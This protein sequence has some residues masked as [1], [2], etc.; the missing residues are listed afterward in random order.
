[1]NPWVFNIYSFCKES[2]LSSLLRVK[3]PLGLVI[4]VNSF[5]V[6]RARQGHHILVV[7][8]IGQSLHYMSHGGKTKSSCILGTI[9]YT[10]SFQDIIIW[11]WITLPLSCFGAKS[12]NTVDS[13]P[14]LFIILILGQFSNLSLSLFWNYKTSSRFQDSLKVF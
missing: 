12:P 2:I 7:Q 1:M 4:I 14:S 6:I 9:K 3:D 5:C 8:D 13:L 11:F 10:S